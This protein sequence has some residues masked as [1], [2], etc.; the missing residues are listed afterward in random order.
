MAVQKNDIVDFFEERRISAA[1]VLDAD[2]KKVR[3]L[4]PQGKESKVSPSR[5]LT[6]GKAPGFPV[7]GARN[8][9]IIELKAINDAREKIKQDIDLR[10]LWEVISPEA[11][12]TTIDELAELVF[13]E[14]MDIHHPAGLLRAIQE[15]RIFFKIKTG[16]I[17]I[18]SPEKVE[19]ALAQREKENQRLNLVFNSKVFLSQLAAGKSP[20]ISEAP[21]GLLEMLEEAALMGKDWETHKT[22]KNIFSQAGLNRT[23]DPFSVLTRLGHWSEDENIRLIAEQTPVEFSKTALTEAAQIIHRPIGEDLDDLTGLYAVAI[24]SVTTRDV[25]D[26]LSLKPLDDGWELGVHITDITHFLDHGSLLDREIRYRATSIYLPDQT[27]PMAP[28]VLSEEAASLSPGNIQPVLSLLI[29]FD[30][31]LRIIDYK[32]ARAQLR[33]SE[34]LSYEDADLRISLANSTESQMHQIALAMRRA[35]LESGAVIF[36]DPE[37]YVYLDE[38]KEIHVVKRDRESPSQILVSESM[39]LANHLFARFLKDRNA[40]AIF[41]SQPEPSERIQLSHEYDPVESFQAKRLLGRGEVGTSPARHSTLG[42]D[43]YTTATSPLR[44]YPDVLTQ[45]QIKSLLAPGEKMMDEKELEDILAL[46]SG[47]LEKAGLMERERKRYYLLKYLKQ[48]GAEEYEA[49]VLH[50]FPKF[51]LVNIGDFGLNAAMKPSEVINFKPGDR[52][53]VKLDKIIPREDKINAVFLRHV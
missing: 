10:E 3:L 18:P 34:R 38:N 36:R 5:I 32:I 48:R 42:L 37:V 50:R 20:A 25:D 6:Y 17:E 1:L 30:R 11:D 29:K 7:G 23:W 45:R 14:A 47:P 26:A 4:T 16:A 39:I 21:E 22:V 51:F 49:V 2:N 44:R 13:G 53:V 43:C 8:E 41:R 12:Q 40:P 19:Q 15:D 28:P 33:V 24:D 31:D 27:I 46:I 35:R 9:Q 52:I